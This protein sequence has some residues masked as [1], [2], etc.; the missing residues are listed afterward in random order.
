MR[1]PTK[2]AWSPPLGAGPCFPPHTKREKDGAP[3]F[4]VRE[5]LGSPECQ[6]FK[7]IP[8]GVRGGLVG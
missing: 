2:A 1:I 3:F 4:L 7:K 5:S 8:F 6:A